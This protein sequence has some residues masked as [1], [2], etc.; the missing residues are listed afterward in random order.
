M[1]S[2]G[3]MENEQLKNEIMI[4]DIK[5][6]CLCLVENFRPFFLKNLENESRITVPFSSIMEADLD[7][8]SDHD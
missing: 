3:P 1:I 6:H 7:N 8:F 2:K 4:E 5:K